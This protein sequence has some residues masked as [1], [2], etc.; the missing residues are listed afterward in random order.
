MCLCQPLIIINAQSDEAYMK[1]LSHYGREM[2]H[3]RLTVMLFTLCILTLL[4]SA[5][6][7]LAG[8]TLDPSFGSGGKV[9]T[10]FDMLSLAEAVLLQPDGKLIAIGERHTFTPSFTEVAVARYNSDGTLDQ[11]FGTGGKVTT[12]VVFGQFYYGKAGVLQPDGKIVVLAY[13][14]NSNGT[15]L[16][17][18]NSNGSFD[19]G[20]GTNGQVLSTLITG[21][22]KDIALQP[23][24]KLVVVGHE[25]QNNYQIARYNSDGSVDTGFGASGLATVPIPGISAGADTVAVQ[26]D[27]KILAGGEHI[28][29]TMGK[30]FTYY[31][32][33]VRVQSNGALDTSFGDNGRIT[34]ILG[35]GLFDILVQPDGKILAN[36][37][38]YAHRYTASGQP[39]ASFFLT[40]IPNIPPNTDIYFSSLALL[41]NGKVVVC[42]RISYHQSPFFATYFFIVILNQDL[43]FNSNLIADFMLR[44]NQEN[45]VASAGVVQPDGKLV[46][47]GWAYTDASPGQL[48][49]LARFTLSPARTGDFDGDGKTEIAVYRPSTGVWHYLNSSNG[50][51]IAISFGLSTDTL[52]PGDYDGDAMTD[53]TIFRNG[54][55]KTLRSTDGAVTGTQWGLSTDVPVPGDYDGDGK[56]DLAVYRDGGWHILRS[57]NG[58]NIYVGWGLGTDK[59]VP[60]DYDGDGKTDIAVYR[61]SNGGWYIQQSGSGLNRV[62]AFGLSTDV[63]VQGDYDGDSKTDLAVYRP[64]NG[65]WYLWQSSAGIHA[66]SFGLST[67]V[68]VPGDYDGDGKT[69]IAVYRNGTWYLLQSRAGFRVEQWG[70]STDVPVPSVYHPQ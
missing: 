45:D 37:I 47:A 62:D 5:Q 35:R 70:L 34:H 58:T 68:P 41:P 39:D 22:G 2:L 64:S 30:V 57:S 65:V 14:G 27:G 23:D 8:G 46:V 43:T 61:P 18:F 10:S 3:C 16:L 55:W 33:L 42:G 12:P 49:A 48:F 32:A 31:G 19:T 54:V 60:G 13:S 29:I 7:A 63:P 69:D 50:V 67:D 25:A 56:T 24:G 44:A 21:E 1:S 20:F 40:G 28:I 52:V 66:D 51:Y 59:P 9:T 6:E 26:P 36:N 11:S 53:R 4:L 17:R 38:Y 15:A